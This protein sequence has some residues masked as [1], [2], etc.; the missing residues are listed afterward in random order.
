MHTMFMRHKFTCGRW[1]VM[2]EFWPDAL[3]ALAPAKRMDELRWKVLAVHEA[4]DLG[5][6]DLAR[7]VMALRDT[8]ICAVQV[9][10][11]VT[12]FV[13]GITTERLRDP[14]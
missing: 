10:N 14:R 6:G 11:P 3:P 7:A 1:H 13:M 5:Q 9:V 2:L 12:G 8:G 4:N